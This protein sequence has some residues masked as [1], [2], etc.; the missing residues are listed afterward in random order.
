M[1][2]ERRPASLALR[3]GSFR[4]GYPDTERRTSG[5]TAYVAWCTAWAL[6]PW[7]VGDADFL[8]LS[9]TGW[10]WASGGI[11]AVGVLAMGADRVRFPL[12]LFAPWLLVFTL[13][14]I[15]GLDQP[16]ATQTYVQT[17]CPLL[18][19]C[20]ASSFDVSHS[21]VAKVRRWIGWVPVLL[22]GLA[23]LLFP[24]LL[25]GELIRHGWLTPQLCGATLW[26]G[27]FAGFVVAGGRRYLVH[28][29]AVA[30][31]P[32]AFLVRG[33][34]AAALLAYPLSPNPLGVRRR[35]LAV[36]VTVSIAT[37]ILATPRFQARMFESGRG[38]LSELQLDNP[39]LKTTGRTLMWATL[40]R[41]LEDAPLL[42]HGVNASRTALS[43]AGFMLAHP[44]NDWLKLAHDCGFLG[45]ASYAFA[46][47]G[48]MFALVRIGRR[49]SGDDRALAYAA[50]G[51]FVP[52]FVL[53][54]TDNVLLYVQFYGNVHFALVGAVFA[55]SGGQRSG[56]SG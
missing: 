30:A 45:V 18:V 3:H 33:P 7:V 31:L 9:L 8:G 5:W 47:V 40:A 25:R 34:T 20:A 39:D 16:S 43:E 48:T 21:E 44:H 4:H 10:A 37:L 29:A 19:G 6:I 51:G 41:R 26:V 11:V 54:I 22:W 17:L 15:R 46:M 14:W 13:A 53:M 27:V 55:R 1:I 12:G 36:V 23:V 42:G 28:L 56:G 24:P 49:R 35:L 38:S 2:V 52:F 50:A 32:V